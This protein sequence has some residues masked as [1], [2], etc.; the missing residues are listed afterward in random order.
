MD[1]SL[2]PL[3]LQVQRLAAIALGGKGVFHE[4]LSRQIDRDLILEVLYKA[5]KARV[6]LQTIQGTARALWGARRRPV[7]PAAYAS[8][9]RRNGYS[10]LA[11]APQRMPLLQSKLAAEARRRIPRIQLTNSKNELMNYG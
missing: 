1:V 11:F 8:R 5:V 7:L 2:E 3:P 10:A 6:R 4:V 9:C